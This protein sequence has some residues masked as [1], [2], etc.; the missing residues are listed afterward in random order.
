MSNMNAYRS[1]EKQTK[2]LNVNLPRNFYESRVPCST[3]SKTPSKEK[4]HDQTVFRSD[5]KENMV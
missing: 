2:T 1:A 3:F 4:R 5:N